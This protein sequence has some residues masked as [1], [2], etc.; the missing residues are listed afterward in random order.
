MFSFGTILPMLHLHPGGLEGLWKMVWENLELSV[1]AS[2][3]RLHAGLGR[4]WQVLTRSLD[5]IS[6][7]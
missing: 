5:E 4:F 3:L 1:V 2:M 6:I 7:R